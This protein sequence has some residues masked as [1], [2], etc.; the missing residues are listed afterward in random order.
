MGE[1]KMGQDEVAVVGVHGHGLTA[2][3]DVA[4]VEF[5]SRDPPPGDDVAA[6]GGGNHGL[7][8]PY[9]VAPV[10]GH[11]QA[12][13]AKQ[14]RDPADNSSS[15]RSAD[16]PEVVV[17]TDRSEGPSTAPDVAIIGAGVV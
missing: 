2:A 9:Q 13:R 7:A 17:G 3:H 4:P 1:S 10:V 15:D 11:T 6:V 14:E 5:R 8:A 16:A 12:A